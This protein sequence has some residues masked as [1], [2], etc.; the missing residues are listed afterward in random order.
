MS[1]EMVNTNAYT[2][3]QFHLIL[4]EGI[5]LD[6]DYPF[7][8]N[9]DRFPGVTKRGVFYPNHDYDITNPAPGDYFIKLYNTKLETIDG[10]EGEILSFYYNVAPDM[11]AGYYQIIVSGVVLGIDSHNG[12][13][14][15]TSVSY[16]KVGEPSKNDLLDLG[17]Y[18]IPSF[19]E[20]K[21]PENNVIING[22]CSNFV[23]TDG[24]DFEPASEFTAT[25]AA[26]SRSMS[27]DWG[28]ICLPFALESDATVQYYKLA[29]VN[30]EAM[31]FEPVTSVEA[32]EPAVFKKLNGGAL[33]INA[34]NVTVTAGSNVK[35]QDASGWT[36]KGTYA[37]VNKNSD[38]EN[39]IY[40]I[41]QNKFWYADK[42]FPVAAFRGWFE[43]ARPAAASAR[44]RMFSI[45]ED[46]G[47]VTPVNYVENEDGTVNVCF[48][49]TGKV[50]S[51]P[52]DGINII[53]GKKVLV[54]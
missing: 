31:T 28:T 35:A 39:N 30:A 49:L 20:S 45:N 27:N 11:Q 21:V 24:Y 42:E 18:E 3:M 6:M 40:Y 46:Y 41:A 29:S 5:T 16:V 38:A 12:V 4:P 19:V 8:M 15:N 54:K 48:D 37:A 13:Y 25:S 51:A 33:S 34:E 50:L 52:R 23:L 14:P 53:N 47:T 36:M 17:S 22:V 9:S 43:T 1:M 44:V 2:A 26:Y 7:D 32:G 10:T